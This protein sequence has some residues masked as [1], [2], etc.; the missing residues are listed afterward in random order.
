MSDEKEISRVRSSE[1]GRGKKTASSLRRK[2]ERVKAVLM[3]ALEK[4]D[5]KLFAETLIDLGQAPDSPEHR[6]SLK[7]FDA[8]SAGK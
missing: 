2:E 5:R 1:I 8:Y 3:T 7:L 4:G 6:D